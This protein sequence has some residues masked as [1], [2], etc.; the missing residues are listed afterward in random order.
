MY[1]SMNN[2]HFYHHQSMMYPTLF[3]VLFLIIQSILQ[4]IRSNLYQN[5]NNDIQ[6]IFYENIY[7]EK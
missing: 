6:K 7:S 5:E 1:L 3:F 2:L 4:I